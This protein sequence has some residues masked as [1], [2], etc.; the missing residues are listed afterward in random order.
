MRDELYAVCESVT[1]LRDGRAVHTGALRNLERAELVGALLG[2]GR[3]ELISGLTAFGD[4]PRVAGGTGEVLS[5]CNLTRGSTIEDVSI[6]VRAGE[7]VGLAGLLGS[8]RTETAR[9]IF[10]ADRYESGAVMVEGRPVEAHAP[11]S[12]IRAG[13]GF[14]SEDRKVDGIVPDMSVADNLTLAALPMLS[15]FGFILR[16]RQ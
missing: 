2:A 14:V 3:E 12:A 16:K 1:V 8:G 5:A 4:K 11:R 7:I 10:G 13:M 15:R 6:D 9:A